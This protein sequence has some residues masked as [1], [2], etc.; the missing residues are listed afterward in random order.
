V[1]VRRRGGD[2]GADDHQDVPA[3]VRGAR[4]AGQVP[5]SR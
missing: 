1:R 5:V 3:R 2:A 4:E